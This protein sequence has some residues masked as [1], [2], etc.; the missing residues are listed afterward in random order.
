MLKAG[1]EIQRDDVCWM[2][3]WNRKS[4]IKQVI[5][6][7][8]LNQALLELPFLYRLSFVNY[9][10]NM[11]ENGLHDLQAVARQGVLVPGE[12]DERESSR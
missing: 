4:R 5:P 7:P 11:D 9:A 10:S 8:L 3:G 1:A 2:P 12:L 6:S